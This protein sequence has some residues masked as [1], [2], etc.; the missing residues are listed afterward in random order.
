MLPVATETINRVTNEPRLR[1]TAAR[2]SAEADWIARELG[3]PGNDPYPL[4]LEARP[5]AEF[6][7]QCDV[8]AVT[9]LHASRAQVAVGQARDVFEP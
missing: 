6:P 3:T 4:Q 5:E 2:L 9:G 8:V 7:L 1:E